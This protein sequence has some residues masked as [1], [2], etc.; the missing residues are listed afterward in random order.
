MHVRTPPAGLTAIL[1]HKIQHVS[2]YLKMSSVEMV[3][4]GA[5]YASDKK[6]HTKYERETDTKTLIKGFG[7]G[8]IEFRL[9]VYQWLSP[10]ELKKNAIISRPKKLK[11]G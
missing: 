10:K 7:P 11:F 1:V 9:W 2:D 5:R 4:F 6:F 8:L 3:A